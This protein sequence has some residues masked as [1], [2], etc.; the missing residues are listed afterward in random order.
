[1][2]S[3]DSKKWKERFLTYQEALQCLHTAISKPNLSLLEKQGLIK[4][5]ECTLE[6]G[7]K[8]LQDYLQFIGI[9]NKYG[10]RPVIMEGFQ[11][12]ILTHEQNWLELLEDRG[13]LFHVYRKN[14]ADHLVYEICEQHIHLLDQLYEKLKLITDLG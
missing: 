7:W 13:E 3:P 4:L 11:L 1:M 12:G 14:I 6:L 8:T 2:N 10:P 5:F 9:Q